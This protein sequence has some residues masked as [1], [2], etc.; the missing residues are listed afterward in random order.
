MSTLSVPASS[1]DPL[2][3]APLLLRVADQA[4][5]PVLRHFDTIASLGTPPRAAARLVEAAAVRLLDSEMVIALHAATPDV[6][7][8]SSASTP[9][10]HDEAPLTEALL[11]QISREGFHHLLAVHARVHP[12]HVRAVLL[13]RPEPSRMRLH[14]QRPQLRVPD[15]RRRRP[16]ARR[17][18]HRRAQRRQRP[19]AHRRQGVGHRSASRLHGGGRRTAAG[20]DVPGRLPS[21]ARRVPQAEAHDLRRA[22]PRRQPAAR[23]RRRPGARPCRGSPAHRR[24]DRVQQVPDRRAP[25]SSA[26]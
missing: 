12:H 19:R 25:T 9:L 15:E 8:D 4:A 10:R 11:E 3:T 22:V 17:V 23:E 24:P 16:D 26:R 13:R 5:Y 20:R 6:L 7:P 21:V 2:V 18:A 1:A 14:R